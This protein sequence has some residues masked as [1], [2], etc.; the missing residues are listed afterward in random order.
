MRFQLPDSPRRSHAR[1]S[2]P[3][4][5]RRRLSPSL[6]GLEG[7]LVLST[8][9]VTSPLDN[10][11]SGTLRSVLASAASGDTI[12]FA[13]SLNGD[14]IGLTMG[15]LPIA[16]SLTIQGPGAGLLD[17]DSGGSSR[18]FD[19]TSASANVTISGLT[20]SGGS[21]SAG[22]GILDQGV[23]WHSRTTP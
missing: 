20:I 23:R 12:K 21:A 17:V 14:T 5:R 9:T 18:V 13:S 11:S 2:L 15:E 7:R 3:T 1:T 4:R 16:V 10:G 22:G 6:E 8:L 19:I